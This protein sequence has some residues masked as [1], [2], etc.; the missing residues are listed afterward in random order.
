MACRV[1]RRA[2]LS[3]RHLSTAAPSVPLFID[4]KLVQSAATE[5][6]DVHDPATG[7][8]LCRTPHAT[9][10]EL[11]AAFTSSAAAARTWQAVPVTARCRVMSSLAQ[12]IRERTPEL[13]AVITA[14]QGKTLA[15][16]RG[17]VFRGLEIVETASHAAHAMM[18]SY[19]EGV[20]TGMDTYSVRQPLGV[21][22]GIAP[23]NFPASACSA[24]GRRGGRR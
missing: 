11:Q 20:A 22:A 12:L 15:D 6:S 24:R 5:F 1:L 9:P 14:E 21:A 23:F 16:A 18:G 10:E 8:L 17:D 13:A 19:A 4:G 7:Q 3:R 2:L